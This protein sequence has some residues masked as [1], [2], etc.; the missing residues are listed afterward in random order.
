MSRTN[1]RNFLI[2]TMPG[3]FLIFSMK[4][5]SAFLTKKRISSTL[6]WLAVFCKQDS[7]FASSVITNIIVNVKIRNSTY[8]VHDRERCEAESIF[9][10]HREPTL[11][12]YV[13]A[14]RRSA[15]KIR[16]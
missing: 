11:E 8:G 12:Q 3:D 14:Y 9:G 6:R 10:T 7:L 16:E 15:I 13:K 4:G 5:I 1:P 2:A